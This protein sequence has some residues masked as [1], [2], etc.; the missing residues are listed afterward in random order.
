MIIYNIISYFFNN[1]SSFFTFVSPITLDMRSLLISFFDIVYFLIIVFTFTT[2]ILFQIFLNFTW[3]PKKYYYDSFYF[4]NSKLVP[5]N[6]TFLEFIWTVVPIIIFILV[7]IPLLKLL[8]VLGFED[9]F[10]KVKNLTNLSLEEYFNL[11]YLKN[12]NKLKDIDLFNKKFNL[13]TDI[14]SNENLTTIKVIGNQWYWMYESV[15]D[16]T[17]Y[18]KV[19]ID[20]YFED[21][22]LFA[23]YSMDNFSLSENLQNYTTIE[24]KMSKYIRLLST[25]YYITIKS[26]NWVSFFIT[27]YDVIHCWALPSAGIKV[28]A[29]P[30]RISS[31]KIFFKDYGF[32]YGQCSELCGFL[33]GFM[34]I[35]IKVV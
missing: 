26:N 12:L 1:Y 11:I 35:L 8:R 33:H 30:G 21:E 4:L 34:P 23:Y 27:A 5:Y 15:N 20:S 7:F 24:E 25:D 18:K 28:D 17:N 19:D 3:K 16:F 29:C 31:S 14:D 32:F 6:N 13:F 22:V 2:W 10:I 9:T